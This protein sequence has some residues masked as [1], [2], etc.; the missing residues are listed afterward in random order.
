MENQ[1]AKDSIIPECSKVSETSMSPPLASQVGCN[2]ST[3]TVVVE[4]ISKVLVF[5]CGHTEVSI[6]DFLSGSQ[7]DD[8]IPKRSSAR[9]LAPPGGRS[10]GIW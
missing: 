6:F 5:S 1:P 9:I 8:H 7:V 2:K 10:S 3:K 4:K